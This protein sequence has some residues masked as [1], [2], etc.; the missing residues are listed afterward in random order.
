MGRK[1]RESGLL[2]PRAEGLLATLGRRERESFLV[3]C[4]VPA[5]PPKVLLQT[6]RIYLGQDLSFR[7][8]I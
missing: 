3:L 2:I 4:M 1:R 5:D 8:F 6:I 7:S